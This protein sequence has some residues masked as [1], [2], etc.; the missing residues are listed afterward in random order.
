[1]L[2]IGFDAGMSSG[3]SGTAFL[4][5]IQ[6]I[7]TALFSGENLPTLLDRVDYYLELA[8]LHKH[9]LAKTHLL[10]FRDTISTLI[11]KGESTSSKVFLNKT[12]AE[13]AN[14]S[15][16]SQFHRAIQAFWI[17]H[18][19]RCHHNAGKVLEMSSVTGRLGDAVIMFFY[20]LN[21]FHVLKRQNIAKYRKIPTNAITAL[22]YASS[23]SRWNFRNKVHLL[24]A[25][26]FSFCGENDNAKASYAAA[27][28]SAGC[29]RFIHEQGLAYECAG[30]HHKKIGDHS[31]A[32][33]FFSRAK[34]CY[35]EWGSQVKVASMTRLLKGFQQI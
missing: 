27:I 29:S 6:H 14:D 4:N 18:S 28:T 2:R 35:Q 33:R 8:G 1:M 20:G 21:S 12:V 23:N 34:H 17:G 7:K 30:I 5:S 3:E 22:K 26:N 25:E 9:V 13:S 24:E 10:M 31:S 11:D 19:E 16:I 32:F 15:A